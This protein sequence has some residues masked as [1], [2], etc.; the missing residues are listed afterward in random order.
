M[1][2]LEAISNDSKAMN[3]ASDDRPRPSP[4]DPEYWKGITHSF[5]AN[6]GGIRYQD[7]SL[8]RPMTAPGL[9]Y[10]GPELAISPISYQNA[11]PLP[12]SPVPLAHKIAAPPYGGM[13]APLSNSMVDM[14]SPRHGLGY[15]HDTFSR[16]AEW[17]IGN[18]N[19]GPY[20]IK[21]E[22]RE[23]FARF[24]IFADIL[25]VFQSYDNMRSG[26]IPANVLNEAFAYMGLSLSPQL[27]Q[28]IAQFFGTPGG[29]VDYFSLAKFI[30]LDSQEM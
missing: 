12:V 1:E 7:A 11:R 17:S 14:S 8:Q 29:Y 6:T 15:Q 20:A 30:E 26:T 5:D 28:H 9:G 2:Y 23:A 25:S 22:L 21:A 19:R 13:H 18:S 3:N 4:L 10:Y 27:V 24:Q 16:S